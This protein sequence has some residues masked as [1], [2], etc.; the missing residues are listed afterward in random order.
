MDSR[1]PLRGAR[2]DSWPTGMGVL[3]DSPLVSVIRNRNARVQNLNIA[4]HLMKSRPSLVPVVSAL[5]IL[6][7]AVWLETL[8]KTEARRP[9]VFP[10]CQCD[11]LARNQR[12]EDSGKAGVAEDLERFLPPSD[13]MLPCVRRVKRKFGKWHPRCVMNSAISEHLEEILREAQT[14]PVESSHTDSVTE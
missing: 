10:T 6:E 3:D 7:T 9:S 13:L 11:L 2:W 12:L 4:F 8:L 1:I 5:W 14:G